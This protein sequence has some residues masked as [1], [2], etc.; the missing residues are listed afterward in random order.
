M[1]DACR[2]KT[3]WEGARSQDQDA[4]EGHTCGRVLQ[5]RRGVTKI[6]GIAANRKEVSCGNI[7]W[8]ARGGSSEKANN[9]GAGAAVQAGKHAQ[10]VGCASVPLQSCTCASCVS[11]GSEMPK[12][13]S[14]GVP[15][16]TMS[17][18]AGL[19]SRCRIRQV[20]M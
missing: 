5:K 15:L 12:S 14:F 19:M 20:C 11:I 18:F 16:P 13:A 17:T 4:E 6:A 7:D 2:S 3:R 9:G 8:S 1:C 10:T